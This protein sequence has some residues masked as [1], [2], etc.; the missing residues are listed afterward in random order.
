[1]ALERMASSCAK[2]GSGWIL[3]KNL[4]SERVIRCWNVLPREWWSHRP[5]RCSGDA[6]VLYQRKWVSGKTL[7][8]GGR[9]GW[10]ILMVF[11]NLDDCYN[12]EVRTIY[13]SWSAVFIVL[14]CNY[15]WINKHVHR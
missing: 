7:V 13:S 15:V 2:G 8:V 6:Y 11:S 4:L 10:I 5:W 1:M 12:G 14:S 3:G 9:F